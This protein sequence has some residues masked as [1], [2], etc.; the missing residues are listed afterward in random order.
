MKGLF[1]FAVIIAAIHCQKLFLGNQVLRI[2]VNDDEHL[3][4][5]KS[6]E[7]QQHLELDFWIPP[8]KT[9]LSVDVRVPPASLQVIK[10]TLES[11]NIQYS[12]M[13]ED[14]QAI[15][16]EEQ[17]QMK[18]NRR[19]ERSAKSFNLGAYH[20]LDT[21][22]NWMDTLKAQYPNLV[23][24]IQIGWSYEH[25]EMYVLKFSTGGLNRPAIWID[26]GIHAREWVSTATAIW[27][28]NKIATLYGNDASLTT[29]LNRMDI[30]LLITANPDGYVFTHTS[31]RM[32]RKTRS[33]N[34]ASSCIG[35]DPNRNWD[36]GFAGPG[37][38]TNP[39]SDSYHGPYAHS[40]VEVKNIVDFVKSHGNIKSFISI[41]SYSQ[42]LLYPYGYKCTNTNDYKELD[43]IG[44][45]AASALQSLY[46]TKYQVGSICAAIYQAS[47]GSIDWTY[48]NG[49][50]YS[51]AFEL[52]DTGRYGFLLPA[53][54]IIPTAEETW[55]GLKSI[56]EYVYDHP[57]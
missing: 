9:G 55:L 17:E 14:V 15:L 56:M 16:D 36:A 38:S 22:Y 23:S 41:H 4:I 57:Y 39:C 6:L 10:D 44:K 28:A 40:E 20:T 26:S 53:N 18:E 50:K 19:L 30:L 24:K 37:A 1:A 13:I 35:V 5:L 2:K 45:S 34:S 3:N 11:N 52:R 43:S 27:T 25:R 33:R 32:W 12:V 48:D 8:S 21:I 29:L 42:L 49:I 31:N 7:N 54:Q 47:G 51:F 46:G